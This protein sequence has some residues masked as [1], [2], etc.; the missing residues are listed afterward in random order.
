MVRGEQTAAAK[1]APTGNEPS[2]QEIE[3][4]KLRVIKFHDDSTSKHDML[5]RRA[6]GLTKWQKRL[7]IAA[8]VLALFSGTAM[9]SVLLSLTSSLVMKII[10]AAL[11]FLSG[12][13]SLIMTTS[14][15]RETEK[16]FDAAAHFEKFRNDAKSLYDSYESISVGRFRERV[17]QLVAEWNRLTKDYERLL[18]E[19]TP[20]SQSIGR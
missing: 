16:M 7:H 15:P 19:L 6:A 20:A 9:T 17:E 14:D 13:I 10:A 18:P 2:L 8:G 4:L 5:F 1:N 12:T 11:A 3:R